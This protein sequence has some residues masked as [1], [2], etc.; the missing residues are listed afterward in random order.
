MG[1]CGERVEGSSEVEGREGEGGDSVVWGAMDAAPGGGAGVAAG[2][3]AEEGPVEV[4]L[5][6][7]EGEGMSVI[8][9]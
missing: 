7:E 6:A 9:V 4:G 8:V 1:E 2:P 5:E 3:V